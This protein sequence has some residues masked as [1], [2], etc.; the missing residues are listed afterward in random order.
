MFIHDGI[1]RKEEKKLYKINAIHNVK[2]S[3]GNDVLF[4]IWVY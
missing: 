2:S 3:K 4:K 1:H